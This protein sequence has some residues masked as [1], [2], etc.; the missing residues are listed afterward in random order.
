MVPDSVTNHKTLDLP[1][2]CQVVRGARN[3]IN[4]SFRPSTPQQPFEASVSLKD[5]AEGVETGP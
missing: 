5:L 2:Q 1:Y 3:T 4:F